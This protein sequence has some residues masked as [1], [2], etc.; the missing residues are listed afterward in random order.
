M[1][2]DEII[3]RMILILNDN[4][5]SG[6]KD[7]NKTTVIRMEDLLHNTTQFHGSGKQ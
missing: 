6:G 1:D 5:Y 2:D 4:Q 7:T 3:N